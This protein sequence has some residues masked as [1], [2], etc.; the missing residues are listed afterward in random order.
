MLFYSILLGVIQGF[1]EFLP[2]SSSGH[3]VLIQELLGIKEADLFFDILLHLGTVFSVIVFFGRRLIP[4][5]KKRFLFLV[6]GSLPAALMGVVLGSVIEIFFSS[7]LF[8]GLAF[9]V[10][11]FFNYRTSINRGK[12]KKLNYLNSFTVG[13]GQAL[14][15]FP[16]ISR[17]GTTIFAGVASGLPKKEAVEFSFLL[18]VPA[19]LGALGYEAISKYPLSISL[20]GYHLLGFITAFISGLIAIKL[21]FAFLLGNKFKLFAFYCLIAGIISLAFTARGF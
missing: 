4:L 21:V 7:L 5:F 20:N 16:G 15:I 10:T 1:T 3:L 8:I 6:V 17:S 19:V 18:S 9:L 14:A 13:L 11:A 2:V 12:E